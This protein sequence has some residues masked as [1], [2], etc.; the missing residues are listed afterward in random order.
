M[1]GKKIINWGL[2]FIF[3]ACIDL[4]YEGIG[5]LIA[6]GIWLVMFVLFMVERNKR[7]K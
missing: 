2:I 1:Y 3:G 4:F 6:W 5:L 7:E